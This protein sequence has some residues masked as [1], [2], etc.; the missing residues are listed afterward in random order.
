MMTSSL[1]RTFLLL[2]LAAMVL[3]ASALAADT[4]KPQPDT[5][6][7]DDSRDA[8]GVIGFGEVQT[9]SIHAVGDR[10]AVS[11]FVSFRT[12]VVI[13]AS[14][15][16][17]DAVVTLYDEAGR[18]VA[19]G[20]ATARVEAELEPGTYF[21]E[22]SEKGDD[23]AIVSYDLA[24]SDGAP[25]AKAATYYGLMVGIDHY[26][27]SYGAS[28]LGSCVN[29]AEGMRDH[30]LTDAARWSSD[31]ITT[32]T[33]SSA[34][35]AA[36]SAQLTDLAST[37]VSGDVVVYFHSS[38]GGQYSGQ[39]TFLCSYN[40]DYTDTELAEDLAA[41]ADG[42]SVMVVID[43]CHSAGM[44]KDGEPVAW[45]FAANVMRHVNRKCTKNASKAPSIGWVTACDYDETCLAGTPYSLFTGYL[46]DGFT[47]GDANGDGDVSFDELFDYAGPRAE[48]QYAGQDAQSQNTALLESTM[49]GAALADGDDG[50][51]DVVDDGDDG[52]GDDDDD[53]DTTPVV[54]SNEVDHSCRMD[55]HG[56]R[57][58]WP[59]LLPLLGVLAF[60]AVGRWRATRA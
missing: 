54:V 43:A 58:G 46:I 45:N 17:G 30:F 60:M 8:A 27:S 55:L 1:R 40:A 29:D 12:D 22:V 48:A 2:C 37:A 10:D 57:A 23:A 50:A 16:A 20:D 42:V 21:I 49:A 19:A 47:H 38:H 3:S 15:T 36:I 31:N 11:F 33:D 5:W 6:E 18:Q 24:L 4:A 52:T 32:L 51:D 41:F 59:Q 53:D 34:T 26:D 39:D 9:R 14:Q 28:P 7:P 44:F 25:V 13:S 56:S 35:E